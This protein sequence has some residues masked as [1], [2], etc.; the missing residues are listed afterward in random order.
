MCSS[1]SFLFK[2]NDRGKKQNIFKTRETKI[3]K[4]VLPQCDS[5]HMCTRKQRQMEFCEFEFSLV[6]LMCSRSTKSSKVRLSSE[7]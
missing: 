2:H 1:L 4:L 6:Y 7:K 5:T 3:R